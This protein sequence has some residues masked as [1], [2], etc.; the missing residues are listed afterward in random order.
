MDTTVCNRMD[1]FSEFYGTIHDC[2]ACTSLKSALSDELTCTY[3]YYFTLDTLFSKLK[4]KLKSISVTS[5]SEH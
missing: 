1:G 3:T 2:H 5:G 4:I